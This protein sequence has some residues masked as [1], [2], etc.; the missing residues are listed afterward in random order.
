MKIDH[1]NALAALK[2][3]AIKQFT[4]ADERLARVKRELD[5]WTSAEARKKYSPE[6]LTGQA[7]HVKRA[8]KG[9]A[10]ARRVEVEAL[11]AK[12]ES[13]R[14]A[15]TTAALMKRA[16]LVELDAES[17]L[18]R[19][20][21]ELK[22]SRVK[23]DLADATP[24]ELATAATEA[25]AS[26]NLAMLAL[27]QR[28]SA[29]RKIDDNTERATLA[30]AINRAIAEIE[31]PEQK[32][33]MAMLADAQLSMEAAQDALA[34]LGTGKETERARMRRVMAEQSARKEGDQDD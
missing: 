6:F 26:R 30:T 1:H 34:E 8:A 31:L 28:E 19:V 27:I 22:L 24:D 17:P 2:A 33:A 21:A 16:Q 29:R 3:D 13:A 9:D 5:D 15:W 12:I 14:Q 18:E 20:A 10:D 11:A 4:A 7:A 32:Q 25:G 23:S